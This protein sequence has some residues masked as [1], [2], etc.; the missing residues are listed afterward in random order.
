MSLTGNTNFHNFT[1]SDAFLISVPKGNLFPIGIIEEKTDIEK[2]IQGDIKLNI[3]SELRNDLANTGNKI[4]DNMPL[5]ERFAKLEVLDKWMIRINNF[6]DK[7]ELEIKEKKDTSFSMLI[8]T[9]EFKEKIENKIKNKKYSNIDQLINSYE[10]KLD[11]TFDSINKFMVSIRTDLSIMFLDSELPS[12]FMFC[13][14]QT[15]NSSLTYLRFLQS[16]QDPL[17]ID[18]KR[19][20]SGRTSVKKSKP[21]LIRIDEMDEMHNELTLSLQR[22]LFFIEIWN[23]KS[24]D[25][26]FTDQEI[27]YNIKNFD[28][29]QEF[30]LNSLDKLTI[31]AKDFHHKVILAV[32][33]REKEQVF[34]I[35]N[36]DENIKSLFA[37]I[38]HST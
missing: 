14:S 13:V 28:D 30:F 2:K 8:E 16:E 11:N 26:L 36:E 32:K 6:F 27:Q 17:M 34:R 25:E 24:I 7:I 31:F 38:L 15:I 12:E 29:Y 23:S 37:N 18:L 10:K 35:Q 22:L 20:K 33:E 21:I 5:P 9:I 19:Y 3:I 1:Y 4:L